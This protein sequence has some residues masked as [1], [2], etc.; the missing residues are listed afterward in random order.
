MAIAESAAK[1]AEMSAHEQYILQHAIANQRYP[2]TQGGISTQTLAYL[3]QQDPT[4]Y[5]EILGPVTDS[6]VKTLATAMNRAHKAMNI[7]HEHAPAMTEDMVRKSISLVTNDRLK[8]GFGVI[9]G[10]NIYSIVRVFK[11]FDPAF[12]I[13]DAD[14]FRKTFP[15]DGTTYLQVYAQSHPEVT[16]KVQ[17]L[18]K[19]YSRALNDPDVAEAAKISRIQLKKEIDAPPRRQILTRA[20]PTSESTPEEIASQLKFSQALKRAI[21]REVANSFPELSAADLAKLAQLYGL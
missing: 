3:Y 4:K 11:V 21:D 15:H 6:D 9:K 5:V 16:I 7:K 2:Q 8:G 1:P 13:R 12:A 14:L 10:A 18:G 17:E 20:G 19:A